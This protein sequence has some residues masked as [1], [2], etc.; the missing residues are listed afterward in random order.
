M[1]TF[2]AADDALFSR[3]LLTWLAKAAESVSSPPLEVIDR[4]VI[5]INAGSDYHGKPVRRVSKSAASVGSP[6]P[7]QQIAALR[8]TALSA[9]ARYDDHRTA[10][11]DEESLWP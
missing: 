11:D 8:K 5:I 1:K 10:I 3:S 6:I 7:L 2:H 9:T 4:D